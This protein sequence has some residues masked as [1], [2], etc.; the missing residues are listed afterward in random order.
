MSTSTCTLYVKEHGMVP[1]Y[2]DARTFQIGRR[3]RVNPTRHGTGT[4]MGSGVDME[5][6]NWTRQILN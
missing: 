6:I 4:G 5:K 2:C 1:I 3:T